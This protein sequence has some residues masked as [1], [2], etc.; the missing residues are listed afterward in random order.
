MLS[1]SVA[2][3]AVPALSLSRTEPM[4]VMTVWAMPSGADITS[5][6][7][8]AVSKLTLGATKTLGGVLTRKICSPL[9]SLACDI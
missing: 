4:K 1:M 2:D 9:A 5:E 6:K 8:N 7:L 3:K